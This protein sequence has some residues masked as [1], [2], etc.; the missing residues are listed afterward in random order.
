MWCDQL[1]FATSWGTDNEKGSGLG[2]N[3][4]HEFVAK[5]N[6]KIWVKSQL[7]LGT[8]FSFTLQLAK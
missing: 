5:H 2:L 4:C 3:L 7:G 8:T 6:G 1:N